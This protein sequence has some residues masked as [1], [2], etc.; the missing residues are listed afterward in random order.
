MITIIR[1]ADIN[2]FEDVMC[3]YYNLIDSMRN[4]EF[5]PLWEKDVYPTRQF[6][7]N[8]IENKELFI[9]LNDNTIIGSMVINQNSASEY[10]NVN[11][12]V[13]ANNDEVIIIHA[14]G[15]L[16]EYQGVGI[17][18]QMVNYVINYCKEKNMKAIRLDVLTQN[19]PAHR[20]YTRMGFVFIDKIQLFYEDTG[21]TDFLLYELKL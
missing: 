21:L 15:V 14:L 2:Q 8:S 6:I 1:K 7:Y 19:K 10:K 20:L 11:W 18:M 13:S 5:K 3:F 12:K 4:I 17:G 16:L 9:V